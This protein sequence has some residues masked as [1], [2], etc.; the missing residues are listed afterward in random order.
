MEAST[1]GYLDSV[2]IYGKNLK[3]IEIICYVDMEASKI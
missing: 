3:P 2:H 1:R